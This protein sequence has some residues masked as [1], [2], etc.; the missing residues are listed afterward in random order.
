MVAH[1]LD[2]GVSAEWVTADEVYGSDS[3][4]RQPLEERGVGYVVAVSCAQRLFV[5]GVSGRADVHAD[6]FAA[7]T[8]ERLSCGSGSKG[9]RVYD[10]AFVPFAF[11]TEKGYRRGL[12]VRRSVAD[13]S[14]KAYYLCHGPEG[15]SAKGFARVA[16]CRWAVE[17]CFELAKGECGLDHGE[18]RTW[19]AWHQHV[20]L[21]LS[22]LAVLAA[23]RASAGEPAAEKN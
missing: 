20:T 14:E 3:K 1:A 13:P 4:F 9:E 7:T 16:G 10:W 12:L 2:A 18:G 23:I 19:H 5:G 21:S 11:L 17:E 6:A 15:T 8:W 22:A